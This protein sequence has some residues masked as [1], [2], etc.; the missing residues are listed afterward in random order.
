MFQWMTVQNN[1]I[2]SVRI[3]DATVSATKGILLA[4]GS[5]MSIPLTMEYSSS[6]SDWFIFGT[7]ADVVDVMIIE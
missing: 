2:H 5:S 7:A 3:G 6:L 4:A 1:A